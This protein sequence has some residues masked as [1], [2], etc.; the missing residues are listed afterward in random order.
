MFQNF[1]DKRSQKNCHETQSA[2]TLATFFKHAT[3]SVRQ[4][5]L[6]IIFN[7]HITFSDSRE[8]V[9][10]LIVSRPFTMPAILETFEQND[11]FEGGL[12][13]AKATSESRDY[14]RRGIVTTSSIT[15]EMIFYTLASRDL[16]KSV[17]DS[18]RSFFMSSRVGGP[19]KQLKYIDKLGTWKM[20]GMTT[21]YSVTPKVYTTPDLER[22]K[23][24]EK[25]MQEVF[26]ALRAT[27]N[28]KWNNQDIDGLSFLFF[29]R[30]AG[31]GLVRS[32]L[33]GD[34]VEVET[35]PDGIAAYHA[36][37]RRRCTHVPVPP[38]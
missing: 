17:D 12:A 30:S 31:G 25:T 18:R 10:H 4:Q 34:D 14:Q 19:L 6:R 20:A 3:T 16:F 8:L 32:Y 1:L 15:G 35:I 5:F 11:Q 9:N 33:M 38:Y 36:I 26:L 29:G 2:A 7:D 13:N 37:R 24:F 27:D 22:M 28:R 23:T 21:V